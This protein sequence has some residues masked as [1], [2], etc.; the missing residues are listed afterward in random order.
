MT[1]IEKQ[2]P[3]HERWKKDNKLEN[4]GVGVTAPTK[5][6][7]ALAKYYREQEEKDKDKGGK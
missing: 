3:L 6:S 7:L 2:I 4:C 1:K 5:E